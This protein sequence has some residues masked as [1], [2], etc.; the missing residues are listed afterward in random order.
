VFSDGH[1]DL[2]LPSLA[3]D[4]GSLTLRFISPSHAKRDPAL[5]H[6][7]AQK[8]ER[9]AFYVVVDPGE[10][11][12]YDTSNEMLCTAKPVPRPRC[13]LAGVWKKTLATHSELAGAVGTL[14]YTTWNG[15]A[16]WDLTVREGVKPPLY[17]ETLPDD[18]R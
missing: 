16:G 10:A 4:H 17:S 9:C 14:T 3:S 1:A 7:I 13:S 12:I 15:H 11:E 6:G 18:C 5:P 8:Y 2:T